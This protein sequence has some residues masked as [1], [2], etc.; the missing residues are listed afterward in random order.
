MKKLLEKMKN[1][2]YVYWHPKENL[3]NIQKHH[4]LLPGLIEIYQ[5]CNGF[6]LFDSGDYHFPIFF[7]KSEEFIPFNDFYYEKEM[8]EEAKEEEDYETWISHDWYVLA[9][10][11]NGNRIAIDLNP[12]RYG[13]CYL[14]NWETYHMEGY[15]PIIAKSVQEFI[16]RC[17]ENEDDYFYWEKEDFKSHGDAFD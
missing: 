4:K 5:C 6:D 10:I 7:S 1:S 11:D 14:A 8:L 2:P 15:M 12:A 17:L 13:Y 9:D 3:P 16:E